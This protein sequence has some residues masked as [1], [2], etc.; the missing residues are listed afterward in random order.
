QH[1]PSFRNMSATKQRLFPSAESA[2]PSPIT[3]Q[4]ARRAHFRAPYAASCEIPSDNS[5]SPELSVVGPVT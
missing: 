1:R 5:I 2:Q 4:A 3:R